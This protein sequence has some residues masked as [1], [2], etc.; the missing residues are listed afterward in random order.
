M[1]VKLTEVTGESQKGK[2]T[3]SRFVCI[4]GEGEKDTE[5]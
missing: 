2:S 5:R 3:E 1:F 4:N